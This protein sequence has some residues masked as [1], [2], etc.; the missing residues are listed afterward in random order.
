M[1]RFIII[2]IS[3]IFVA[4][5]AYLWR[6]FWSSYQEQLV[7]AKELQSFSQTPIIPSKYD[8]PLAIVDSVIVPNQG[9]SVQVAA[10]KKTTTTKP[11]AAVKPVNRL[12]VKSMNVDT[13]ILEGKSGSTLNK[14]IWHLPGTANP[15]QIGN[16]VIA[17]HRWKWLPTSKKSFYDIDKMK[18]GDPIELTWNGK[19]YHYKVTNIKTVT[20]DKIEVL[21][22]TGVAKLTLFSCAPLFSSKYRLVV[23]AALLES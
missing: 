18:V 20:P 7:A 8:A 12:V 3:L 13:P 2:I 1:K 10:V 19:V 17:A 14:G 16:V 5:S 11:K 6:G 23:E 4:S 21:Q 22:N 15:D 9:A